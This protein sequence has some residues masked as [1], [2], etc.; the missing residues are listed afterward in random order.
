MTLFLASVTGAE[1][2][3]VAVAHG[4]DIIDL[5][6]P[7]KGALGAL[8]EREVR[9]AVASIAGKRPVSAVLG[10]LPMQPEAILRAATAMADTGVDFM[11]VG[12]FPD[13][14]RGECIRA[15]HALAARTK[16]IGVMFADSAPDPALVPAMAD[17]G[18]AGAMLDTA[19]KGGGRLLD[20]MDM[21]ALREFVAACRSRR[22]LAGLAGS[23]ETPDVPRLLLL[24]PDVLG[25]RTALCAN[26]NRTAPIDPACVD[27]VRAL[28]PLDERS[29]GY[30]RER[31][32]VDYRLLAARGYSFDPTKDA[33]TDHVFVHDFVLPVRIG[34]YASEHE[35]PQRVRFNVDVQVLRPP[36]EAEDMRDV[37]SYDVIADGICMI[38]AL[39][40]VMLAETLAERIAALL[41]EH[42][43]V[44]RAS[45]RL[46][47]L[48]LG[49]GAVGVTIERERAA[50]I[51]KVHQLYPAAKSDPNAAE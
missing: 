27:V 32:G 20:H 18:F 34:V 15:L 23:L 31:A 30:E 33:P 3:Q 50:E 22:M 26:H 17:A 40:H 47:K 24:H 51:A 39:G 19:R 43:R 28:I 25:F 8:S 4:A 2:A 41:L 29:T 36:H 5:K 16:I 6:D 13:P 1:E 9:T 48:D 11:K 7:G 46:E 35:Q 44:V 38:V 45:V 49:P 21:A 14:R 42:P 12:L 10:D 37:F